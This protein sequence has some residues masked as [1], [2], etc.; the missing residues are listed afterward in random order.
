MKK[1]ILIVLISLILFTMP[2]SV[3]GENVAGT[4]AQ[5][6]ILEK[7]NDSVSIIAQKKLAIQRLLKKYNSPLLDEVDSFV[8]ACIAYDLDCYLLPAI[9]GLE[10]TFGKFI[11]PNSHNPFGWVGELI[12]FKNWSQSIHAVGK[13]LRENYLNNGADTV[14]KIAPIYAASTT[15]SSR[16]SYFISEFKKEEENSAFIIGSNQVKL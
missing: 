3:A 14:E 5:I 11:Y 2:K 10:S 4:S 6:A 15:W 8:S 16:V 9:S 1:L 13:G 12:M 7:K